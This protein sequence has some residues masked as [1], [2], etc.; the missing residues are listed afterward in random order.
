M[1]PFEFCSP[2]V[3]PSFYNW[4]NIYPKSYD[5]HTT[6]PYTKARVILMNGCETEQIFFLHSFSH[7]YQ[8]GVLLYKIEEA[9]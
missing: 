7:F 4:K 6:S 5:K 8:P 9:G 3:S 2:I 1:N